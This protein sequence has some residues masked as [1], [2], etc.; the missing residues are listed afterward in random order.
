MKNIK[1]SVKIISI[2]ILIIVYIY[3]KL[4]KSQIIHKLNIYEK[5]NIQI[6]RETASECT[7]FLKKN[8]AFPIKEPCKVLLIGSG[9]RNTIKGGLGSGDVESRYYT[10][11]E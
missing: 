7:L 3:G 11:C 6:I 8:K 1:E 9:A 10:T 4:F 2:F 5:E